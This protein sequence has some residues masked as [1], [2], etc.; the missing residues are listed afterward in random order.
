MPA[1]DAM[2]CFSLYAANNAMNRVYQ[3]LLEPLGLTY[4]QYLVLL[5]LWEDEGRAVGQ[6]GG[7]IGLESNTLTPLLKRMEAAGLLSRKRNPEDERQVLV[8]LTAKG[9]ALRRKAESIPGCIL[10]ASGLNLPEASALREQ[11]H[12]LRDKLEKGTGNTAS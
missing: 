11:L 2:L 10:A 8:H 7:Q 3:P 4:P 1:I 6:I 9:K 5:A 12:A